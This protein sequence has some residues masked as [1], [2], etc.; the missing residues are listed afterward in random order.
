MEEVRRHGLQPMPARKTGSAM[1]SVGKSRQSRQ[2][3]VWRERVWRDFQTIAKQMNAALAGRSWP[4]TRK[5][6][7]ALFQSLRQAGDGAPE[8]LR[9]FLRQRHAGQP[10]VRRDEPSKYLRRLSHPK[11]SPQWRTPVLDAVPPPIPGVRSPEP[12]WGHVKKQA[13]DGQSVR[14]AS[15]GQLLLDRIVNVLLV[16]EPKNQLGMLRAFERCDVCGLV[17]VEMDRRRDRGPRRVCSGCRP[18]AHRGTWKAQKRRQRA[19]QE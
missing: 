14:Y 15:P 8:P 2:Q 18:K 11:K 6:T 16:L 12:P 3:P 9:E 13:P 7:F 19:R 17:F 4:L 5:E 10:T 1:T